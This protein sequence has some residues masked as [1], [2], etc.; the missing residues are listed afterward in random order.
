MNKTQ[1][2]CSPGR[3]KCSLTGHSTIG[4]GSENNHDSNTSAPYGRNM[5]RIH[6]QL[7]EF[8]HV[9]TD[10]LHSAEVLIT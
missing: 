8:L 7:G 3:Q 10:R 4:G 6:L 2:A 5:L 9:Q 1:T